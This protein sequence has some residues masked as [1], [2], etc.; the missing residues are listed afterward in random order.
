VSSPVIVNKVRGIA[1]EKPLSFLRTYLDSMEESRYTSVPP[2]EPVPVYL[3]ALGPKMLELAAER[4]AGAHPYNTTPEH[5]A[6]ARDVMGPEAGLCVEQKVMLTTDAAQARAT[7]AGVLKFYSRAPGYRNAWI[8]MGFTEEDI[9]G[10]SDR[11]VDALV[12]WGDVDRIEARLAEHAEA[13]ATHICIQPVHPEH[14]VAAVDDDVL[15]AL[16]PGASS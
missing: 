12:A 3:A 16:A 4:A 14:G 8:R 9:D 2:A 15:A 6:F 7:G 5:T 1:Y 11:F 13:G 10:M